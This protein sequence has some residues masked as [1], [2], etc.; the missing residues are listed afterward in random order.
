MTRLILP[1]TILALVFAQFATAQSLVTIT[2]TGVRSARLNLVMLSEGYTA[3]EL[4]A[5]KFKNDATTISNALLNTEPFKSYRPFFNVYG[6]SVASVQSGADGGSQ[7]T[8][9]NTYFNAFFYSPPLDRLLVI[10]STGYSRATALLNTFVPEYDIV[11]VIVNDSKYGGSGGAYAVTSTNA[12]AAEIAIHEIGHSFAGLGDEYDYAGSTPSEDPNT[13]QE[14]RRAFIKWNH[15]INAST[16][17][18]TPE[19]GAYGNGLVGLFEGA[20]YNTTGWYRPTLDSKMNS[21]GVP[22]YAVNEEAIV[23]SIYNRVGPIT[24]TTPPSGTVTVNQPN[25]TLTFTVSGPS[26]AATAPPITVEWKLDGVVIAG[27]TARTL[28]RLSTTIGNGTHTLVA[29]VSDPTTKVRKDTAGLLKDS[30]TWTLNLSNQGPVAPA[31]LAAVAKTNGS[32]DLTWIDNSTDEAGFA[33]ERAVGTAATYSEIGRVSANAA[34]YTDSATTPGVSTKYRVRGVNAFSASL[35]GPASNVVTIMPEIAPAPVADP[36]PVTVM[37]GQPASFTVQ[38]TGIPLRYQWRRNTVNISGATKSIYS[39]S[40]AQSGHAGSYDCVVSNDVGNYTSAAALLTVNVPATVSVHPAAVTV[41]YDQPVTLTVQAAGTPTIMF[42]WRKN[43]VDIPM[44]TSSSLTISTPSTG[45]AASYDCRVTNAYGSALSKA[46]VL[47]VLGPPVVTVPPANAT[48]ERGQTA[49]FTIAAKGTA[50]LAYQW[51]KNGVPITGATTTKLTV[52]NAKDSDVTSYDCVVSNGYGRTTSAPAM[53]AFL[54]ATTNDY[55]LA[56]DRAGTAK[57]RWVQRFTGSNNDSTTALFVTPGGQIQAG[58]VS[59]STDG[60]LGTKSLNKFNSWAALFSV[61]GSVLGLSKLGV[62]NA[63]PSGLPVDGVGSLGPV[64]FVPTTL[65]GSHYSTVVTPSLGS[66]ISL[67]DEGNFSS[68]GIAGLPRTLFTT[69]RVFAMCGG[70]NGAFVTAGTSGSLGEAQVILSSSWTRKITGSPGPPSGPHFSGRGVCRLSGDTFVACGFSTFDGSGV[71]TFENAPGESAVTAAGAAGASVYFLVCYDVAGKVLWTRVQSDPIHTVS[72]ISGNEVWCT[73]TETGVSTTTEAAWKLNAATGATER[74]I[75]VDGASSITVAPCPDGDIAILAS[76]GAAALSVQGYSLARSGFTVLKFSSSGALRWVL[77]VFGATGSRARLVAGA[78]GALYAALTLVGDGNAEFAG[79]APF[80][81]KGRQ[82]DAFIAAISE[83]PLFVTP[84]SHQIVPLGQA[85]N[86]SVTAGGLAGTIK[87]QWSKDGKTLAG[88]IAST[89]SIAITKLTDAGSYSCKVTGNGGTVESAKAIVNIVDTTLR[90]L[91]SP[92]TKP[93]DLPVSASGSGLSYTWWKNSMRVFNLGG[94]TNSTTSKL[95]IA[96]MSAAFA[97]SYVC[98]V[99]GPAGTLD[100]PFTTDVMF[101]PV[102]TTPM[103]PASIVSGAFDL[104]LSATDAASY[105]VSTL[106]AGLIYDPKTGRITGK[107]TTPGSKLITVT[108]TNAAGTS[109]PALTFTISVDD[110]AAY[111]KGTFQALI[112]RQTWNASLGGFLSFT[113]STSGAPTGTLRYAGASH[114]LA[115]RVD[116]V[117]ATHQWTF[118][119][120]IARTGK[121][122]LLLNLTSPNA[123]DGEL[124]GT[125]ALEAVSPESATLSGRQNVWSAAR[126]PTA[127][128]GTYNATMALPPLLVGDFGVPQGP[129]TLKTIINATTGLAS[130]SAKL[131]D[132]TGFS[133]SNYVWPS[134]AVPTWVALYSNYG[135]LLGTPVIASPNQSGTLEWTRNPKTGS[136]SWTAFPLTVTGTKAP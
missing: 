51:R 136:P 110:I 99:S 75:A 44:A 27:Q 70:P 73:V 90:T 32:I 104:Q 93:L 100:V 24:G 81:M 21:L 116:A 79:I 17:I 12:S 69:D 11:L 102:F 84:P 77:P 39:I 123:L 98:T 111:A 59:L 118:Y 94:F 68:T 58:G 89:L 35:L 131:G 125:L 10:D 128:A 55:R 53:I 46:A 72:A 108:A 124:T 57:W 60:K 63:F 67:L 80:A 101:A 103:V 9:R 87:Y 38:A 16:P 134:G 121:A 78:D 42:Q 14:T 25:Q 109:S 64:D 74:R 3:A 36:Q 34:A 105:K 13:T 92:N 22:F 114:S 45:D 119:Q 40:S 76:S 33:I 2:E 23:L 18:A 133:G 54:S 130:W 88:Q 30:R 26:T 71:L 126:L 117:P 7:G 47:T 8:S 65:G 1:F 96:A 135:S 28:S 106:P 29:N 120:R 95:R 37:Q 20:A 6:I 48:I 122:A 85:L 31:S 132:N 43:T 61:D 115:G 41:Y 66:P 19:I 112:G 4:S 97:D 127:F 49:T 52:A 15:W 50:T 83:A 82:S 107:P 91:K 113:L 5:N 56:G 129:N 86:L 62:G